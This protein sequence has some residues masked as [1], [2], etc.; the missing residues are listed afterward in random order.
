MVER[1]IVSEMA[2]QLFADLNSCAYLFLREI[3]EP[4]ENSLRLIIEEGIAS[5][6]TISTEVAGQVIADCHRVTSPDNAQLFEVAWDFYVAYSIRNESY[7]ARD[8][9]EKFE[10]G[11][12]ARIYSESKFLEYVAKATFACDEH[13]GPLLHVAVICE[14]HI[15]DV[16]ST[17]LPRIKRIRPN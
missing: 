12:L 3:G 8:N 4:K 17:G 5:A 15:V 16:I 6:G 10:L 14:S 9:A 11:N 13:P 2:T 7:V 1:G